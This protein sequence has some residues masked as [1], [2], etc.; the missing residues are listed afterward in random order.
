MVSVS[1]AWRPKS[2]TWRLNSILADLVFYVTDL[3]AT[4]TRP[5][6]HRGTGHGHRYDGTAQHGPRTLFAVNYLLEQNTR[7]LV[8]VAVASRSIVWAHQIGVG[9]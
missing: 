4:Y 5:G 6:R 8:A 2:H 3:W 1:R 9:S 7:G